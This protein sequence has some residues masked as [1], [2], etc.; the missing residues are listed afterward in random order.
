MNFDLG[1]SLEFITMTWVVLAPMVIKTVKHEVSKTIF[2]L[3]LTLLKKWSTLQWM[4]QHFFGIEYLWVWNWAPNR[5]QCIHQKPWSR[6]FV[7][8]QSNSQ[9]KW[10]QIL[11]S[12]KTALVHVLGHS[13]RALFLSLFSQFGNRN[14][15]NGAG[16]LKVIFSRFKSFGYRY[17]LPVPSESSAADH[18]QLLLLLKQNSL[19]NGASY[20]AI[21]LLLQ[22]YNNIYTLH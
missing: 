21:D 1:S 16:T 7:N 13:F 10:R 20:Y 8:K 4:Q 5:G 2:W 3:Q 18:L 9:E 22:K 14:V 19:K 17:N 6:L 12:Y 11:H 15:F